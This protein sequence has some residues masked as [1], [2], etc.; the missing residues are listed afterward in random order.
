MLQAYLLVSCICV[1]VAAVLYIFYWN[2]FV[3]SLIGLVLRIKYWNQGG[4]SIWVQIGSIHFSILA[5]RILLKDV[6]YH[7]SNQ[8][9][10]IVKAQIVWRYWIRLPAT[11]D[12]LN[13]AHVGG[14]DFNQA[15]PFPSCRIKVSIQGLEWFLYNRT[16]AYDHIISQMQSKTHPPTNAEPRRMFSRTSGF[17]VPSL[18]PPSVLPNLKTPPAIHAAFD[19]FKRQM[20]YLD[21]KDL[22]PIA[23]EGFKGAII[24]GNSSTP[25]LL[26]AEFHRAEGTFGIVSSRSKCDLYK[27]LLNLK[28]QNALVHLAEHEGYQETMPTIGHVVH[29]R[30]GSSRYAEV[31]H[32]SYLSFRAFSKLWRG[33]S[34]YSSMFNPRHPLFGNH[35]VRHKTSF[36]PGRG[37]HKSLDDETPVGADFNILEYAVERRV[38]EAPLLELS[39]YADVVGDVPAEQNCAKGMGLESFDIGNGDLPPE[40]G[41]DLVIRSGALRYGP[42]ADRQRVHLQRALFP[43]TYHDLEQSTYLKPGDKRTWTALKVFVELREETSLDI[44]FREASKNWQWD[45][46]SSFPRPRKRESASI[47]LVAGDSS[48]ISYVLPMVIGPEGYESR[49]EVHL[50]TITV[51]SSL[52]DIK[53]LVAESCRVHA[54]LPSPITWN[55]ERRW[56]FSVSLRQPIIYILRDHINLFTDLSRDWTSG[57]PT[58]WH[59]FVPMV[60]SFELDLHYFEMN[61]YANDQNIIDK[62]LNRDENALVTIRAPRLTTKVIIPSNKYHPEATTIPF[63][64]VVSDVL[65]CLSL[66]RW[67]TQFLYAPGREHRVIHAE[68]FQVDASYHYFAEVH[69]EN[70]EQ[71][72]LNITTNGVSFKA[73]GWSIRYIM[74]LRDNYLGSFTHFSTLYEYLNKRGRQ[75]AVGDP[76]ELKYRPGKANMLQVEIALV[77]QQGSIALPAGLPGYEKRI[78]GGE[79]V[80][81]IG[82]SVI[83]ALSELQLDFRLHDY[84]MEMSLNVGE[85]SGA[86][87]RSCSEDLLMKGGYQSRRGMFLIDG[88]DITAHRLFGPQ[89]RTRTYVCIWEISVG[90]I[91]ALAS[92][93]D[94]RIIMAAV[95]T[96]R[97]NFT[98]LPNAPAAEFSV[99]VDPD[100]TFVK[101]SLSALNV[102]WLAGLTAV[103]LSLPRGLILHTNDLEGHL[104]GKVVNLHLPYASLK[105]LVTSGSSRKLW[106]EAAEFAFD[107]NLDLYTAPKWSGSTNEQAKFIREQD[108]LTHRAQYLFDQLVGDS[109]ESSFRHPTHQ[110]GLH[111]PPLRLPRLSQA[112]RR[113]DQSSQRKP[114]I[115]NM[116]TRWSRVSHLSESEGEE[117]ISEADRDAR[118]R[119]SRLAAPVTLH[120]I[121]DNEQSVSGDESDDEDLTDTG[122]SDTDWSMHG[123]EINKKTFLSQYRTV[124]NHYKEL[125]LADL[126]QWDPSPFILAN[127]VKASSRR[128]RRPYRNERASSPPLTVPGSG[129]AHTIRVQCSR[130]VEVHV[131]P[132]ILLAMTSLREEM[133]LRD[134]SIELG[135]DALMAR[136]I[137]GSSD[138]QKP[139]VKTALDVRMSSIWIRSYQQIGSSNGPS[140]SPVHGGLATNS[141][142]VTQA[143]LR[144][145]G[146][147]LVSDSMDLIPG[148]CTLRVGFEDFSV[149]LESIAGSKP[150]AALSEPGN[151]VLSLGGLRGE[152]SS[153]TVDLAVEEITGKLGNADPE[154]I[155]GTCIALV[156]TAEELSRARRA[157]QQHVSRCT[158]DLVYQVLALTQDHPTVDLLSTTQPSYLVQT[159]RPQ[160][161]RSTPTF[162]FLFYLRT[163]LSLLPV[164]I[165]PRSP[166]PGDTL[167]PHTQE[168]QLL[169]ESCLNGL[170]LDVDSAD[171]GTPIQLE[172]WSSGKQSPPSDPRITPLDT[173]VVAVGLLN[174]VLLDDEQ[175]PSSQLSLRSFMARGHSSRLIH[176]SHATHFPI[177]QSTLDIPGH[178]P[179]HQLIGV[180]SAGEINVVISPHLMKFAQRILWVHRHF[181]K[182]SSPAEGSLRS[183]FASNL[184]LAVFLGRVHIH[185]GAENLIFELGGSNLNI[186]SSHLRRADSSVQ[187]GAQSA[188]HGVVFHDLFLRA[189]SK[190]VGLTATEQDVLASLVFT[191]GR[192]NFL[193]RHEPPS[194]KPQIVFA[195]KRASLRV[196]RSALRLYRFVEEW[197][198]DFLP[199][200]EATAQA[201]FSDLMSAQ[202]KALPSPVPPPPKRN[203]LT[204]QFNGHISDLEV[205]LQVMRGTWLSWNIHDS[206]GFFTSLAKSTTRTSQSF[207]LQLGSQVLSISYR[208]QSIDDTAHSPRVK[209][210]LPTL[211]VSGNHARGTVRLL[212]SLDYLN[213]LIKPS[214]WDT[215]LVVQQKFG[216][217]FADL[218]D[219]IQE[220][221]R[222]RTINPT[223]IVPRS[224]SLSYSGHI[225]VKGFRVGLEGPSSTFYLECEDVGG[226]ISNDNPGLAWR[227]G[228][229]DLALSLAPR[230]SAVSRDHGFNRNHRSAFVIIDLRASAKDRTLQV[231]IPKIEA[232]M[233]PSSIGELGDFIDHQQAEMLVRRDQ[234]AAELAAFKEKTQSVLRTFEVNVNDARSEP[235]QSWLNEHTIDV[236]IENIGVAFPLTLDQDLELPRAG[237]RDAP[238]VR[239]FLFAVR[240]IKFGAQRGEA[241]QMVTRDFSFQFVSSFRQSFSDDFI[242][243]T[244]Q[245]RN[246][247][248]YPQMTAQVRS[249]NTF[250]SRHIWV[251]GN[252]SGFILDIDSSIPDYVFSLIDVYRQGRER[253]ARLAGNIPRTSSPQES[254]LPR[255]SS[256]PHSAKVPTSSVFASLV[257]HS[258]E[259]HVRNKVVRKRTISSC[260]ED[261]LRL[262]VSEAET[263]RLPVV[264]VWAEYRASATVDPFD[265]TRSGEASMLIFKSTIHSSQNT[266]KP[267]LLPFITD[268]VDYI[269]I[270]MRKSSRQNTALLPAA[271]AALDSQPSTTSSRLETLSETSSSLQINFSLRIDKSTLELTCL[272]DVNVVAALRWDS[273]GFVVNI[274]P[275]AHRVTF[276]GSVDGL[277][278]GLKHGF[279]SDDCVSLDARNLA[280]ALT[281]AKTEH[282][283]GSL[284]SSVSLVVGTDLSGAVR[285]SR[286]QD[287]LCFKA[288]WLDRIPL[289]VAQHPASENLPPSAIS[290][291]SSHLQLPKH[292]LT[293]AILVRVRQIHLDIDLGQSI[294]TV[295]LDLDDALIRTKFSEASSEVSLS[296]AEVSILAKG[297]VSGSIHV[298]NCVFQTIRRNEGAVL[299]QGSVA[300]MLELSMTSGPLNA[301]LESDHQKLL[302]YRAEPVEIEIHDDWSLVSTAAGGKD[303]PLLVAFTVTGTE[304][305]VIATIATIP[306]LLLYANKF[307]ANVD[308]QREGAS[309]ESAAFRVT[310]SP[311]PDN[312]LSEVASAMLHSARNRFREA[313]VELSYVIRQHMSFRLNSLRLILF[314]RTMAD[315]ELAQ[316]VGN[317]VHASLDRIVTDGLPSWR[318][319]H[320]SFT[321]MMISKF[322]QHHQFL[323]LTTSAPSDRAWLDSI[324]KN[325]AEA[326]IVGLPSMKMH[327]ITEEFVEELSTYLDYDFF[328]EFARHEG[329]KNLED[330]YITLNV[331]LYSWL[332]GLRKNLSREMD[333]A[334]GTLDWRNTPAGNTPVL[335]SRRK[336]AE[337]THILDVVKEHATDVESPRGASLPVSTA[338]SNFLGKTPPL[339]FTVPSTLAPLTLTTSRSSSTP[340]ESASRPLKTAPQGP[341]ETD[342]N[343][344]VPPT[345]SGKNTNVIVYRPR[346]RRI[347]R[348]TMRQ[349]GEATPDVMHPF[350]M[351]KAGFNLEDSL[352]QY[353]HEYATIPLEEIMEALLKLYSKQLR[354]DGDSRGTL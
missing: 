157:W 62:P 65:V 250:S 57:P 180:T 348:L 279:L 292:E 302:L 152:L 340:A 10:K 66:P 167:D 98:D 169:L 142:V 286:L 64:L 262:P 114:Q 234:R 156:Q 202:T 288:V 21:P 344:A 39:Y 133:E 328:S 116:K 44:P 171:S 297:N 102:T 172:L 232:V 185:A 337:S 59:Q 256:N 287:I 74:V 141:G 136:C 128:K 17:E 351:K 14:D 261:G 137:G 222:K 192:L 153:H 35:A 158:Q 214:H 326:I 280:F 283:D 144:S 220:T 163:C 221:R 251:S 29:E 25:N 1:L 354:T 23:L 78:A 215:L 120:G 41:V 205:S 260:S 103:D 196:P 177:A 33:L 207:G 213:I 19:W 139:A 112:P 58:D 309:R 70:I 18:H 298:P 197:R 219:L 81:D 38:L 88:I 168:L 266:L 349:L 92:A 290:L 2:R 263:I 240:H 145:S 276:S 248:L 257:F 183:I 170:N 345:T 123:I 182:A 138:P 190:T 52:N 50:D 53:I 237:S 208:S 96:F 274:S 211:T 71:L 77:L 43:P 291:S 37:S 289:F 338:Q 322:S 199:G 87:L 146:F 212:T 9:I 166:S 135:L 233:Q 106:S 242:A 47:R 238:S 203:S 241:G 132:L 334:Q 55:A 15:F 111:L 193:M 108:T 51:T 342:S 206:T 319:V 228:L 314:P 305:V 216:Q 104:H 304:I 210:S 122:S 125:Y 107:F 89:P 149:T 131:S 115:R 224:A 333:Q 174:L 34:L 277:T 173:I 130:A 162:R 118:L 164:K 186:L 93:F 236:T 82:A 76:I 178:E 204:V 268:I 255:H 27:Q 330:I 95:D 335:S 227:I 336:A 313:E 324:F 83:L 315:V 253:M 296:V 6:R 231:S 321:N 189:R 353:V 243:E 285:F 90:A 22:L 28:F 127:D 217:D 347:E 191:E 5:G 271:P 154:Y 126:S 69:P 32:L 165:D 331:S 49:L 293:T 265:K 246:R 110:S 42:W 124:L 198:A 60:Y 48:S 303:R 200:M 79:R 264:S 61:L 320:L 308:A 75:H 310:Q 109:P 13:R 45:G 30:V 129:S 318:E 245:T 7:S 300:R 294:S 327:M 272:P 26:V 63:S 161:L 329:D 282:G 105:L 225:K 117:H 352:P 159:G 11:E 284:D 223:Q 325:T 218:M 16:A 86:V 20:P 339:G 323:P 254:E 306:K 12:D 229:W 269:Q 226:D 281:F 72:R 194:S 301:E 84:F 99:P 184:I 91:K 273:G 267:T 307:K 94:G 40:W 179:L 299:E 148:Q 46:L 100:V 175:Q 97:L 195:L 350:F 67:N 54:E 36:I 188:N 3:A 317:D 270:R 150:D 134:V 259:V 73:L 151:F 275:G 113:E 4:S 80:D 343:N 311:K 119:K 201:L 155:A 8:T 247:L 101:F 181:G 187:A 209:L 252:V 147:Y 143:N 160:E 68:S 239:A 31:T 176:E 312:P 24:C 295:V 249:D 230:A 258:G 316:F 85:I 244:H 140:T 346:E 341:A 278:A 332:T 121:D 235:H 56:G